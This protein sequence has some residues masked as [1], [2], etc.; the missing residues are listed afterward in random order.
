MC[1]NSI[2]REAPCTV[3]GKERGVSFGLGAMLRASIAHVLC[4]SLD[5]MAWISEICTSFHGVLI[6]EATTC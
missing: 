1:V 3:S 6:V 5:G 2:Q 4:D